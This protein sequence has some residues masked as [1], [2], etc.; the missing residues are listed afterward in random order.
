MA[1]YKYRLERLNARIGY[2][3]YIYSLRE[4]KKAFDNFIFPIVVYSRDGTITAANRKFREFTKIKEDNIQLEKINIFDLLDNENTELVE[5]AHM[6][7]SGIENVY[8][9]DKRLLHAKADSPEDYLLSQFP[10]AIFYPMTYD[11]EGV[12]L[13]GILLDTNKTD[14]G[15]TI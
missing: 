6:A 8:T 9:G 11:Q 4:T 14:E 12:K 2:V 5:A 3:Q 13:V 10:N 7:F 15:E 1:L